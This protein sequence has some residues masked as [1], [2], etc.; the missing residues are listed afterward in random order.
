MPLDIS[1]RKLMMSKLC[2]GA[3]ASA[4]ACVNLF[5][6]IGAKIIM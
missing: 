6:S 5:K 1:K 2:N 3:G 4:I